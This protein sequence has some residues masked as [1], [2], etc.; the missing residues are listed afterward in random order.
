MCNAKEILDFRAATGMSR[1]QLMLIQS[2]LY[3]NAIQGLRD[4]ISQTHTPE[5]RI[6]AV[7]KR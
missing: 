3:W 4:N 1:E 2:K 7:L 6:V 5:P